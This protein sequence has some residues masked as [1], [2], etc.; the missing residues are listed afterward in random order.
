MVVM[1]DKPLANAFRQLASGSF[2]PVVETYERG[3]TIFFPGDPAER[4]Y[5]LLKGAV[6]LSRVYEAGKRL[7]LPCS[8]KIAFL[9]CCP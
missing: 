5:F 9:G 6:K 3:K 4:V 7:P 8:E 2:P 1:Q